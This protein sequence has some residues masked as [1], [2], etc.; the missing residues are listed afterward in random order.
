MHPCCGQ[1]QQGDQCPQNR[2]KEPT[3]V[4]AMT[5]SGHHLVPLPPPQLTNAQSWADTVA[6]LKRHSIYVTNLRLRGVKRLAPSHKPRT[7]PSQDQPRTFD[8]ESTVLSSRTHIFSSFGL[9]LNLHPFTLAPS[10]TGHYTK[11][12]RNY[13]VGRVRELESKGYHPVIC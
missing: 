6:S 10:N 2:P 3:H 1:C 4:I 5:Q 8:S 9:S 7:W 12:Q 11:L 13:T